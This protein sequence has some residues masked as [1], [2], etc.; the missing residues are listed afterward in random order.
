[1]TVPIRNDLHLP[2]VPTSLVLRLKRLQDPFVEEPGVMFRVT[3]L[4]DVVD[5]NVQGKPR[6]AVDI[7]FG[8]AFLSDRD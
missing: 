2:S 7:G 6:I 3:A 8:V 5:A 1:M 4:L